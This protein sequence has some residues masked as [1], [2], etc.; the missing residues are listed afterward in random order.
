MEVSEEFYVQFYGKNNRPLKPRV[1]WSCFWIP[2]TDAL[3]KVILVLRSKYSGNSPGRR[4]LRDILA[5]A[6]ELGKLPPGS[7]RIIKICFEESA[8]EYWLKK[9]RSRFSRHLFT[10]KKERKI[11]N[12]ALKIIA[13]TEPLLLSLPTFIKEDEII[14][15]KYIFVM[16]LAKELVRRIRQNQLPHQ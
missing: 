10:P 11:C 16:S 4:C 3:E 15:E 14:K 8:Y 13:G 7:R 12:K 9:R 5:V 2:A 6:K 1:A